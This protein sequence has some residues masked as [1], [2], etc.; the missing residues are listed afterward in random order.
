VAG[1]HLATSTRHTAIKLHHGHGPELLATQPEFRDYAPAF[2][3]EGKYLYFL[4]LRTYDPVYDAVQFELSFPRAARPYLI[5]L[6]AG[7]PAPFEPAP[8]GLKGGPEDE[9]KK[10]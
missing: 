3:P 5:A 4:S 7:G 2:D 9:R 8:R 10:G 6:Q 1:L